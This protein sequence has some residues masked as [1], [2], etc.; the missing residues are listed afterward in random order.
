MGT[1]VYV[2]G[3]FD[4]FH[5]GH[6]AFLKK[7]R[8]VGGPGARL[9]VGVITDEDARWKRPTI[10]THAERLEMVRHC[11]EVDAVVE[12]PPLTLTSDFLD[13]NGIDFV[14]HGG[15]T[16]EEFFNLPIE[17]EIMIYVPY[18]E[19][20][21]TSAIIER[22]KAQ[23]QDSLTVRLRNFV[24]FPVVEPTGSFVGFPAVEP[25]FEPRASRALD[26]YYRWGQLGL[27]RV[28]ASVGPP[29]SGAET[30]DFAGYP[31]SSDED[32][33]DLIQVDER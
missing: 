31:P 4:L 9:L 3:V 23:E 26:H 16:Q 30:P 6:I 20:V 14:V 24:N 27:A 12:H 18:T 7:A 19:G 2:N 32:V 11:T 8:A 10:M 5:P 28:M 29:P 21:S 22:V 33:P 15:P 1:T 25:T 13:A 17:R